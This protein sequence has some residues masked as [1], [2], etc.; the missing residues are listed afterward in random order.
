MHN[1]DTRDPVSA[2]APWEP[3][4]ESAEPAEPTLEEVVRELVRKELVALIDSATFL[5]TES[6]VLVPLYA[7]QNAAT[8]ARAPKETT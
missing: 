7:L 4:P 5:E 6:L 3:P 1:P 8:A 2:R